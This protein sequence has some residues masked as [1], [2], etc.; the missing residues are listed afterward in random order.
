MMC[1]MADKMICFSGQPGVEATASRPMQMAEGFNMF[2]KELGV[3]FR[4]EPINARP[5]IN[6]HGSV[7][8]KEQKLTGTYF[9][10]DEDDEKGVS[11]GKGKDVKD[12]DDDDE[13]R[14]A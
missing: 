14:N 10:F 1:A 2:L 8:D 5:R 7:K 9:L 11:M 3:T 13:M 4:R 6:K 12:G